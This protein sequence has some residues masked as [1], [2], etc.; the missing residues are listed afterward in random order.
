M[1]SAP[2]NST[3]LIKK[4]S[5]SRDSLSLSPRCW[6]YR[7][8]AIPAQHLHRCWGPNLGPHA[9]VAKP[10]PQSGA[11]PPLSLCQQRSGQSWAKHTG[12]SLGV[13]RELVN[14]CL[15]SW[16]D[17]NTLLR[18]SNNPSYTVTMTLLD[19]VTS[20][21]I[22][23]QPLY[24]DKVTHQSTQMQ[25]QPLYSDTGTT[26]LCIQDRDFFLPCFHYHSSSILLTLS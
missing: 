12:V 22:Q 7:W 3:N 15:C 20:T 25:Q 21:Q 10:S 18:Y 26:T 4:P 24:S 2:S 8:A 11:S 14:Y 5:S 19:I 13:M 9:C 23:E 1:S 6:D 16:S 17:S